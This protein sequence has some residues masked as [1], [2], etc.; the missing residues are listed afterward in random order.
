MRLM[1]CS[2]STRKFVEEWEWDT[3]YQISEHPTKK[4]LELNN[5]EENV[6]AIGGGSVI[7][8]AKIISES[9]VLAIPTTFAGASRTTHAVY[10]ADNQKCD[11][12]TCKPVTI[13]KPEYLEGLSPNFLQYT[14]ADCISHTIESLISIKANKFSNFF[15]RIAMR[16]MENGDFLNAS[17]LAGDAMEIAGTNVIHALSY[18]LTIFYGISHGKALAFILPK[19]VS[20]LFP[21]S[22]LENLVSIELNIDVN[23]VVDEAL[24]YSKIFKSTKKINKQ[25]LISWLK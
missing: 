6:I 1:V 10:L 16:L 24:K 13:I 3:I 4:I 17:L 18:P 23:K 5:T 14:K 15:A 2:R 22:R 20:H 9:P 11:I 8:T 19:V 25:I 12:S 21:E 7:D